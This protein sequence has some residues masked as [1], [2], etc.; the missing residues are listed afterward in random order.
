[1]TIQSACC[2]GD[3]ALRT[4]T[5]DFGRPNCPH[6]GSVLLVAEQSEFNLKG[7]IRHAWS[8]DDCGHEFVTSIRLRRQH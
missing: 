7:R 6:C 2:A 4:A 8:C 1:M 3:T 5:E